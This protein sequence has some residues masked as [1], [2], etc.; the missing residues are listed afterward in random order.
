MY[1]YKNKYKCECTDKYKYRYKYIYTH[2][3]TKTG[4]N[5]KRQYPFVCCKWKTGTANFPLFAAME[6][7]KG[8]LF[9]SFSEI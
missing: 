3:H 1:K 9:S 8:R 5:G 4:T 6:M 7:E 2:R